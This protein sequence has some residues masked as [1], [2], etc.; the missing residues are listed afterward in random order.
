MIELKAGS[1]ILAT[2]FILVSFLNCAAEDT[3]YAFPEDCVNSG[4]DFRDNDL[5][6]NTESG[7]GQSLYLFHNISEKDIWV[8]HPVTNDPG[9][10]AGWATNLNSGNWSAFAVNK[11]DF[12]LNCSVMG[13]GE[14]QYLTCK[15]VLKACKFANP[16][17]KKSD[18]GSYWVSENKTLDAAL[19]EVK[20]RGISW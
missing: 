12:A 10:S 16:D 9:A 14:I 2:I 6:L 18:G 15:E 19:E 13:Q 5:I 17:F 11:D 3:K 7:S 20:N 1:A 8:N 4:F